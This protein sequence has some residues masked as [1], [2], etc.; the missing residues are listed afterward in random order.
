MA[1][2]FA[3]LA[4]VKDE[5]LRLELENFFDAIATRRPPRVTGEQG[6]AALEVALDILA[7]I[8]EHAELVAKSIGTV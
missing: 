3:P 1:I 2:D 7:K 8:E 4:V 5:P 6:K